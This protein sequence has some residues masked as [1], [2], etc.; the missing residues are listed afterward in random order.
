MRRYDRLHICVYLRRYT[1]KNQRLLFSDRITTHSISKKL[2]E[3]AI[4]IAT[5][6]RKALQ[7][8]LIIL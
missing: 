8:G 2:A 1:M 6:L 5:V 7:S 3:W 4:A